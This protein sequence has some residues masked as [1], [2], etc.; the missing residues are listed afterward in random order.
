MV[1]NAPKGIVR[2]VKSGFLSV[3]SALALT[4]PISWAALPANAAMAS[5]QPRIKPPA[6][7]PTYMSRGDRDRLLAVAAALKAKQFPTAVTLIDLVSD[8]IAKGLGQ[9][10]YFMAEDPSV[11]FNVADMFLDANPD[12]P[13]RARIHAFI[14]KKIPESAPAD[15]V[16]AFFDSREPVTAAGKIHLARALFSLGDKIGGEQQLRDAWINGSL[17]IAE[18]KRILAN[19]GGRLTKEDHAERVDHLLWGRQVTNARRIFP[20]LDSSE[21]RK[22]EARAALLLQAATAQKLFDRL[23]EGE[24]VDSGVLMAAVR[25]HRRRGEEQ[26]AMALA[27]MA[28]ENPAE[29]RDGDRWWSERNLLMRWALK[30][31]RFA[32]AYEVA[33]GHRMSE[34]ADYAEAEFYAGWI[35]L[36][37]LNAPDRAESH[38]LALA[39]EVGSPISVSRAQYWLGRAAAAQGDVDRAKIYYANAATHYY[40]YYGQLAAEA[41]GGVFA[42]STF[43]SPTES[44]AADRAL[45]SSRPTVA[46]L[47][48]LSDLDLEYE[49][50]VFAYHVDDQLERPG[51]YLELAKLTDG[52]GAPH[53]TVRAGKVAIQRGAFTPAVAYPLVYVPDEAANFIEPEI[54]LGLSRQESEFNPRA[55]SRAGARGVM[56]LIPTTAQIT[57]RKEGMLY[58]RSA[59]L[60]DPVYNMT[61]GS[62]HVSHLLERFDGSLV[63]TLAGYNAGAARVDQWITDYG[64]PRSDAVDP[65]DWVE[66]IPFSET[67]N[68]VQR[69]LENVQVYRGR[70]NSTPIPGKLQADIERGGARNRVANAPAPSLVLARAATRYGAQTLPPLPALTAERARRYAMQNPPRMPGDIGAPLTAPESGVTDASPIAFTEPDGAKNPRSRTRGKRNSKT[71]QTSDEAVP[72]LTEI[73]MNEQVSVADAT[74]TSDRDMRTSETVDPINGPT[75]ATTLASESSSVPSAIEQFPDMSH[76][77][78]EFVEALPAEVFAENIDDFS[79]VDETREACLTYR[80]FLALNAED[81]A[82][83][84]DLNAGMLAEIQGGG[85]GC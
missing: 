40:S 51:E 69:V 79:D 57:A 35:A 37:F 50:M 82:A 13:A 24:K 84:V 46:A 59:L 47:R 74:P 83:A 5:L 18:E 2:R 6:P 73:R 66:L 20:Y 41:V 7:G 30:N 39:S 3:L 34:G 80:E 62:A 10:M 58:S 60:D 31:G 26:Y 42:A 81:E 36:R 43:T 12:W 67:R 29:I 70:I 28:P 48:M 63:M 64:D 17:T 61:I 45:F 4:F 16:L 21:R 55:Y 65:L 77:E 75:A 56:Q 76:R 68:Y 85:A 71:L 33:A 8:P 27:A 44:T 78:D 52:E 15:Q 53:L 22:A 11:D 49:F 9:W 14:E 23:P 19:Y 54:I 72:V 38:F 25:Y 1:R 32:D